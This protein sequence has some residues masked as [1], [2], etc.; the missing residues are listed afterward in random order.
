M[1]IEFS[2][3]QGTGNDFILIDNRQGQCDNLSQSDIQFYCDRRFGIGAD[4][5]ILIQLCTDASF[6]M[7][8]YNSDGSTSTMCGNGVRCL[9]KFAYAM[10]IH[11]SVYTFCIA[12]IV[13]GP[14][15][16]SVASVLTEL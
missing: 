15:S 16:P 7:V 12:S 13:F 8:Y 1:Q 6:D 5:L 4:G 10:G 2:K 14:A 3:Y 9:V 11:K